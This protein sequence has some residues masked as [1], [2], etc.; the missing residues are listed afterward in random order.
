MN[1][2]KQI[3]FET[4]SLGKLR[5]LAYIGT[6]A[7]LEKMYDTPEKYI[8]AVEFDI[9]NSRWNHGIYCTSFKT[10]FEEFRERA[11]L[12]QKLEIPREQVNNTL[13]KVLEYLEKNVEKNED[14]NDFYEFLIYKIGIEDEY[15][16]NYENY[17]E[18]KENEYSVDI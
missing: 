12:S 18:Q 10:A 14:V 8:V 13:N 9:E 1:K 2:D 3:F 4:N 11:Y 7:L 5:I 6:V 17:K 15:I 16:R